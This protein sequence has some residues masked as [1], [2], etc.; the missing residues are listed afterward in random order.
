MR[1]PPAGLMSISPGDLDVATGE[2]FLQ[3]MRA[4]VT[5]GDLRAILIREPQLADGPLFALLTSVCA[6]REAQ[7]ELWVGVHDR[8]HLALSTGADGIH[9]GFRSLSVAVTRLLVG[10][11]CAIGL[12]THAGDSRGRCSGAD[13]LFH[14]PVHDTPSK[15]GLLDPLGYAGLAAFCATAEQPVWGLGGLAPEHAAALRDT[16][17]AGAAVLRGIGAVEDPVSA[18]RDWQAAWRGSVEAGS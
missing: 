2:R 12:S 1:R 18:C 17:A 13:Y 11:Q 7:P 9:L 8:P 10:R 14:G 4:C 16:G 3:R 5:D 6:L 15:R